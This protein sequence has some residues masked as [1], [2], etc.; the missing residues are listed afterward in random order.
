MR[1]LRLS[2]IAKPVVAFSDGVPA[3]MISQI[4]SVTLG[5][6]PEPRDEKGRPP[7]FSHRL[8]LQITDTKGGVCT[9]DSDDVETVGEGIYRYVHDNT[10]D[11]GWEE[12]PE[13][14]RRL[15]LARDVEGVE[16]LLAEDSGGLILAGHARLLKVGEA[17]MAAELHL[18]NVRKAVKWVDARMQYAD[19]GSG[20]IGTIID[21][22]AKWDD[23]VARDDI[24]KVAEAMHRVEGS[25]DQQ[26]VVKFSELSPEEQLEW[27]TKVRARIA[28]ATRDREQRSTSAGE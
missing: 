10:Y 16:G 17:R 23:G 1:L 2:D 22:M 18:G 15:A 9:V 26:E 21:A 27:E 3:R 25:L 7:E 11:I 5:A 12:D 13:I 6:L 4:E 8:A 24:L 20:D 14:M 19:T 28:Q